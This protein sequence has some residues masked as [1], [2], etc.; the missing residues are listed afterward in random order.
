M[1]QSNNANNFMSTKFHSTDASTIDE[2]KEAL[3]ETR[4]LNR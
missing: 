4:A 3:K 1:K 2:V